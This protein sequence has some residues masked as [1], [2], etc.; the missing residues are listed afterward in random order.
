[1]TA[2]RRLK[3]LEGSQRW[4]THRQPSDANFWD[5]IHA[6]DAAIA[7]G[8]LAAAIE[9]GRR[10]DIDNILQRRDPVECRKVVTALRRIASGLE[11][12]ADA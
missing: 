6:A 7:D 2:D 12:L 10:T 11:R 5:A 8:D 1:M 4:R 9:A 3:N